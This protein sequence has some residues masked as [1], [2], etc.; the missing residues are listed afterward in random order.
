[1]RQVMCHVKRKLNPFC[2]NKK[3]N[4]PD[5]CPET[6]FASCSLYDCKAVCCENTLLTYLLKSIRHFGL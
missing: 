4:C 2:F 1:V 3:M 6:C 5:E